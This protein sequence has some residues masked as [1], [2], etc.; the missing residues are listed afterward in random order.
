ML[1][2][3]ETGFIPKSCKQLMQLDTKKTINPVE[4]WVKDLNGR[5]SKE[6]IQIAIRHQKRCSASLTIGEMQIKTGP[7][8]HL[9]PLRTAIFQKIYRD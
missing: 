4:K 8:Y 9:T 7:W 3:L 1:L 6:G 2:N 5:L